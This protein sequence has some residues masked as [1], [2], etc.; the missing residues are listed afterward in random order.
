MIFTLTTNNLLAEVNQQRVEARKDVEF[1]KQQLAA[2]TKNLDDLSELSRDTLRKMGQSKELAAI[3][4]LRPETDLSAPPEALQTEEGR[5]VR[6]MD[7]D[8]QR[9]FEEFK[10]WQK[11]NSRQIEAKFEQLKD[12]ND[13]IVSIVSDV[14][15]DPSSKRGRDSDGSDREKSPKKARGLGESEAE[16][17]QEPPM[18]P[19]QEPTTEQTPEPAQEATTAPAQEPSQEATAEA[20]ADADFSDDGE[21]LDEDAP[22]GYQGKTVKEMIA[23]L[24]KTSAHADFCASVPSQGGGK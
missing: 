18:E 5:A 9:Q 10:Q 11:E 4:A 16:P 19:T 2:A 13:D 1:H 21:G 14:S 23:D 22:A 12:I 3:A 8:E 7:T 6:V 20:T 15:E 17:T 24:E